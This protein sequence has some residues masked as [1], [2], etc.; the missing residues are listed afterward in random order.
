MKK[1]FTFIVLSFFMGTLFSQ[2]LIISEVADG[3][4]AGGFPKIVE[5]TNTGS[6]A[7]TLDGLKLKM[8]TNGNLTA[9]STYIITSYSLPAGAS[10][11]MTNIDNV[12]P[13]QLWTDFTLTAPTHVLYSVNS[14]NSNG[15]DV[16][17]FT[18]A[19]DVVID[20]YGVVGVDGTG[21]AWEFLD[22]YAVR[23]N[24]I[25]NGNQTFT[26]SE[27][28]FAGANFLDPFSADL[29]AYLTPGIHT[30]NPSTAPIISNIN[31]DP[32]NP[33]SSSLVN[34]Y[35]DVVAQGTANLTEVKL[36]WGT[37]SE[38]LPN[39]II[40]NISTGDTYITSTAIPA[41]IEGTSVYYKIQ[42]TDDAAVTANSLELF[43]F[44]GNLP[45][46]IS[47]ILLTPTA[48]NESETVSVS[49]NISDDG[50]IATAELKWGIDGV[51]FGTTINMIVVSGDSYASETEIP[52]QIAGTTVYYF[53]IVSDNDGS[54]TSSDTM[55][56][57][58][59][60]APGSFVFQN[61]GFED[62]TTGTPDYWTT[63]DAG[64]EVTEETTTI[65]EGIKSARINLITDVQANTDIL[66]T[67][68]VEAGHSYNFDVM[69]YQTDTFAR[70]RIFVGD[71]QGYSD[72]YTIG[73]WQL[74][75]YTYVAVI[76]ADIQ[77]GLRFYDRPG[78][79]GSSI[80]Y[81][82]G[83]S[84]NDI[85]NIE[86]TNSSEF[87]VFPNPADNTLFVS[88]K[89]INLLE[90]YSISGQLLTTI[91]TNSNLEQVNLNNLKQG[92]YI[93]KINGAENIRFVKK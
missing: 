62:W 17:E 28:T 24:D 70:A 53:I 11:V 58:T 85:T 59:T 32:A 56:Y 46:E 77:I 19:G 38:V 23:N 87:S 71:Y 73:E 54:I 26:E 82:D 79:T 72:P 21:T 92:M 89:N 52:A 74:L 6:S 80:F 2:S 45:P 63:I 75:P 57:T 55:D 8:Y 88:G 69:I 3:T 66:Q 20:V 40:M 76:D 37:E 27:W 47:A 86:T 90:V 30:F 33:T 15:N 29:S 4:G 34:V 16:Y 81:V 60:I 44:I 13:G 78:F 35:A 1:T 18:D 36:L 42:A 93:L 68:S 10:L 48:P 9:G 64:I 25:T 7:A 31:I 61:G 49:A 41:Q 12:T 67:I 51:T 65:Y 14:V 39:E 91:Q 83:F 84:M 5:I 50:T 43:Y 22:S